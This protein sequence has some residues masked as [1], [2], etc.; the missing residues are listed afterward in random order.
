MDDEQITYT[1]VT[2][3]TFTNITRGVNGTTP[4]AHANSIDVNEIT[5]S[6]DA[7]AGVWGSA[8]FDDVV[9]NLVFARPG[10]NA[11]ISAATKA[12][13]VVITYNR[14]TETYAYELSN[15]DSILIDSVNGMT[16]LNGNTYTV[17]N[18]NTGAKTFELSGVDGSAYGTY[19]SGGQVVQPKLYRDNK[20]NKED[21]ALMTSY[22][23]RTGYDL[24]DP[25]TVKLVTS[26]WPKLEAS[27]TDPVNV[28]VG[29]QM[30][31]EDAITWEGPILFEP[32][33]QSKISCRVSGK[34]FGVKFESTTDMD[35]KLHGVAF[36]VS[37]RGTRGGRAY[38]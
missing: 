38:S 18:I 5:T 8:N 3:T 7:S 25:S 12:D 22:V 19:T 16:Q 26:V 36:D 23:E 30:S 27:G 33:S 10:I 20:G 13:P 34:Y 4:A 32:N 11:T 1:G 9:K 17:A 37:P 28:Y 35:W 31:T 21:T 15:G 14:D 2:S 24:G 6:W 29:R